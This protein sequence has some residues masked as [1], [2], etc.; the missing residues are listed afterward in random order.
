MPVS[1]V[2]FQ[3]NNRL[4]FRFTGRY[5]RECNDPLSGLL[6]GTVYDRAQ[7]LGRVS[8]PT[9]ATPSLVENL[10]YTLKDLGGNRASLNLSWEDK[11]AT[12][13]FSVK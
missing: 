5:T 2:F 7:D 12:V 3:F 10:K 11:S 6:W 8:F 13:A 9:N 4:N 1:P